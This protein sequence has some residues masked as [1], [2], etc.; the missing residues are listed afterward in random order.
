LVKPQ[1]EVGPE[2]VGSGGIVRSAAIRE[3]AVAKVEE[4]CALNGFTVAGK[5]PSP[6]EGG[7]GNQEFLLHLRRASKA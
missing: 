6:L 5:I 3:A 4:L 1:F 2:N 7:D